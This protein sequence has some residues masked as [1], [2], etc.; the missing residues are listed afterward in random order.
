MKVSLGI[1][2]P[3]PKSENHDWRCQFR[4]SG[5]G[6][7]RVHYAH[8]IDA[9]QSLLLALV[10]IRGLLERKRR[11]LKWD[12]GSLADAFPRFV[13][14]HFGLAFSRRVE[15]FIDREVDAL[16]RKLERK[17]RKGRRASGGT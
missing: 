16:S 9:F 17:A 5:L 14:S 8:G 13:P 10:G 3:D 6:A 7:R 4:V 12:G 2:K 15:G 11:Q 1:P